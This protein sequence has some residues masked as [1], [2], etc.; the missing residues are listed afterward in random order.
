MSTSL[1]MGME[2]GSGS[3]G[4]SGEESWLVF[5]EWKDVDERCGED[6]R[7]EKTGRFTGYVQGTLLIVQLAHRGFCSSHCQ[8]DVR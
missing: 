8:I 2:R 4:E 1:V 3:C 5:R 7:S 6:S